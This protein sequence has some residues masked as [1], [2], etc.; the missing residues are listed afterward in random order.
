MGNIVSYLC[1]KRLRI[2][3]V[4]F[5]SKDLDWELLLSMGFAVAWVSVVYH[6]LVGSL[7]LCMFSFS[8]SLAMPRESPFSFARIIRVSYR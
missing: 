5:R 2:V 1:S 4:L 7:W 8:V 6:G 3:G